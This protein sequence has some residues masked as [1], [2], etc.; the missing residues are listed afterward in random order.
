M[1]VM[2]L[3]VSVWA[4]TLGLGS[5]SASTSG[6][7]MIPSEPRPAELP[8]PSALP[9]PAFVPVEL[10]TSAGVVLIEVETERAPITAANF[11]RYVD[12]KRYNGA[13][14]YRAMNLAPGFG[15][16][17]GG[18]RSDPKKVLKPIAHEPTNKTGLSH[19]DGALSMAR[20][21]PGTANAEFF[22]TVGAIPS[23]DANPE[24]AASGK[25]GDHAGFAVFG[26]VISGMP[27]VHAI[28]AAPTSPT[29]GQGVMRGQMLAQ[30]VTILSARRL[31]MIRPEPASQLS[32]PP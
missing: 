11:L 9:R 25:P 16:I 4:L 17:Q 7:V 13:V 20:L 6:Q 19:V 12:Q 14:F 3:A 22:I 2:W 10:R 1:R 28:L 27:V 8:A 15:L 5:A 29:A 26:K 23:L 21:A 24:A 32:P 30:P 31:P 18:V